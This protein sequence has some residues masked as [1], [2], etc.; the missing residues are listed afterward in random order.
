VVINA[1]NKNNIADKLGMEIMTTLL[2]D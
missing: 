2:N 1:F